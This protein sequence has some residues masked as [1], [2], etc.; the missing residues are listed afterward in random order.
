MNVC[1]KL[2]GVL[3][4]TFYSGFADGLIGISQRQ[5]PS[6]SKKLSPKCVGCD[7]PTTQYRTLRE[8]VRSPSIQSDEEPF[9]VKKT[10]AVLS[11]FKA[12]ITKVGTT[13]T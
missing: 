8:S 1:L 7:G 12:A 11:P 9:Q 6:F 3:L 4:C 10:E 2:I 13:F 5:I